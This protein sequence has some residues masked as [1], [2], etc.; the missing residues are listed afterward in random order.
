MSTTDSTKCDRLQVAVA[1]MAALPGLSVKD[2]MQLADFSLDEREDKNMRRKVL[3]RLPGKEKR[4]MRELMSDNAEE[5]SIMQSID[6]EN[7]NNS[8]ISP[9][10]DN[11]ATN[12]KF[13]E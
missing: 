10:T 1:K 6:V 5:G 8:D 3:L 12:D 2:A 4:N 11:S 7:I 13:V 9:I